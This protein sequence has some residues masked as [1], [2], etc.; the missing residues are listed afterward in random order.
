MLEEGVATGTE[1]FPAMKN[2]ALIARAANCYRQ[3]KQQVEPK[4]LEFDV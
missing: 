2:P 1:P 4:S 3:K